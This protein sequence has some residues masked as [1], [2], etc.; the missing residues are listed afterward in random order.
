MLKRTLMRFGTIATLA[1]TLGGCG[2]FTK[3]GPKTT[4]TIG[5]RKPVLGF[6]AGVVVDPTLAG[7]AVSLPEP[8]VNADWAQ[9][10]GNASKSLG[11]LALGGTLTPAFAI[12]IGRGSSSYERLGAPP[13]I[14]DGRIYTVDV[15][16]TVHAFNAATGAAVWTA[17]P[18]VGDENRDSLFGGGASYDNGRVYATNGL[19]AVSA[20]DARTGAVAWTVRPGGPLRGAPTVADGNVY[21]MSQDSQIYSLK[22]S[23]GTT[24]WNEAATLEIA[25]VFGTGAPAFAQGT[26]VAGFSSGDLNA[27]RYENGRALWNDALASTSIS[28]S[29]ASLSD[30]DASPVIDRGQ[31]FAVGQ[32][33]RM[34]A[35]EL[36]TGQRLW[37][38]N[39][40]GIST[41][42][43]AGEWLFVVTDDARLMCIAR[44]TGKIRWVSQ[45]PRYDDPKNK[46]GLINWNGPILAGGR[47]ILVSS[48]GQL[49][50]ASPADGAIQSTTELNRGVSLSPVVANNTLYI[51]DDDGRLTAY[52]G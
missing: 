40:A 49:T 24:Q 26:V 29:V 3:A 2:V 11:H 19:G 41:P 38:L 23:D 18:G 9:P 21:V 43:L 51:L 36:T 12:S 42:W 16:G 6:D 22:A 13:T 31:V 5:E 52:R 45:L 28:T 34:V 35:L 20:L 1:A 37:E 8:T 47:L 33:G 48:A 4:P 39:I 10:G 30:I 25:G 50:Y 44:A 32:G 46:K 15:E 27:Y 7:V 17:K 14:G